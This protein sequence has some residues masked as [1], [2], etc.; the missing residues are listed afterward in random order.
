M[1]SFGSLALATEG[2]AKNILNAAPVH[3]SAN[4]IA[5]GML[6]NI[7]AISAYEAIIILFFMFDGI[8]NTFSMVPDS[9]FTADPDL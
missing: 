1:D 9:L 7:I 3:R 4:L 2:P 8:G 5:P 6:R